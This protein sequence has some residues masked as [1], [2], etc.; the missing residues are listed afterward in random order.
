MCVIVEN[1][2]PVIPTIFY[3]TNF[4]CLIVQLKHIQLQNLVKVSY[5]NLSF[6]AIIFS[7]IGCPDNC[8]TC[9]SEKCSTCESKYYLH[10]KACV[11]SCPVQT[12]PTK[13]TC[14]GESPLNFSIYS[15]SVTSL[16]RE[17]SQV[18]CQ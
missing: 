5:I 17:L 7:S 18:R 3:I 6:Y 11:S 9:D 13:T 4:V 1:A 14:E 15:K 8:N 16:F 12:Y 2:Q 10:N